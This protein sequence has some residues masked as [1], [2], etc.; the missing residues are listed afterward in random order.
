MKRY[1][2]ARGLAIPGALRAGR[3]AERDK[4][5]RAKAERASRPRPNLPAAS[6]V[7]LTSDGIDLTADSGPDGEEVDENDV[8]VVESVSEPRM[9]KLEARK[10]EG[11]DHDVIEISD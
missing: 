5:E 9:P 10:S 6:L 4:A 3:K 8:L 7:D 11:D 2:E 1:M